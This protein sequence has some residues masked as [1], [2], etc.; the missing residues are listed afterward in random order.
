MGKELRT[1]FPDTRGAGTRDEAPGPPGARVT[2][3]ADARPGHPFPDPEAVSQRQETPLLR[4]P[5]IPMA[6]RVR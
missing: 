6:E 4:R 3:N 5:D 1:R 2:N